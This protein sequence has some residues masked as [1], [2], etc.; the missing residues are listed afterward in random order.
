MLRKK[1]EIGKKDTMPCVGLVEIRSIH[2]VRYISDSDLCLFFRGSFLFPGYF[3][4]RRNIRIPYASTFSTSFSSSSSSS[5]STFY[6]SFPPLSFASFSIPRIRQGG[7]LWTRAKSVSSRDRSDCRFER[8]IKLG[9]LLESEL[10]GGALSR[11]GLWTARVWVWTRRKCKLTCFVIIDTVLVCISIVFHH[12]RIFHLRKIYTYTRR[13]LLNVIFHSLSF[14]IIYFI[15]LI[16]CNSRSL[17]HESLFTEIRFQA[18]TYDFEALPLID[19]LITPR[20]VNAI[21]L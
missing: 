15:Y 10:L 11:K 1:A 14:I 9:L 17:F 19:L 3:F 4:A 6:F 7:I 16:I 5:S 13:T 2:V 12:L 18:I 21:T 20:H 8:A